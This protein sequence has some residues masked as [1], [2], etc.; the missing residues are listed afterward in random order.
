MSIFTSPITSGGEG[1]AAISLIDLRRLD[2]SGEECVLWDLRNLCTGLR[3]D[4]E[5]ALRSGAVSNIV[6][7]RDELEIEWVEVTFGADLGVVLGDGIKVDESGTGIS[8]LAGFSK[9][10]ESGIVPL[11]ASPS[12]DE[13]ST[14]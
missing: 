11:C 6:E 5:L 3:F 8:G 12:E 14:N 7:T 9:L 4:I 10:S 2:F 13:G 1:S